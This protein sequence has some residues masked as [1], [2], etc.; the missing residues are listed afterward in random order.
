MSVTDVEEQIL[1]HFQEVPVTAGILSAGGILVEEAGELV[2]KQGASLLFPVTRLF[3]DL[4][5]SHG[6]P[7][8][9]TFEVEMAIHLQPEAPAERNFDFEIP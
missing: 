8:G 3:G 9:W 5:S 1:D 6:R 2:V 4:T 7:K